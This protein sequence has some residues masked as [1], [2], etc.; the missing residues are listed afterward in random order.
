MNLRSFLEDTITNPII[1]KE[2]RAT[3][4]GS[5][6]FVTFLLMLCLF[7]LVLCGTVAFSYNPR[8][9][10]S[11]EIGQAVFLMFLA[12]VFVVSVFVFPAFSCTAIVSE[13]EKQTYEML[14]VTGIRPWELVLG[15]FFAC[16]CY[17]VTFITA[18]LPL[19][20]SSFLFGG[21]GLRELAIGVMLTLGI[22]S[23][24]TM[25][26][27]F[28]SSAVPSA[29]MAVM[30]TYGPLLFLGTVGFCPCLCCG[31]RVAGG[32]FSNLSGPAGL[33]SAVLTGLGVWLPAMSTFEAVT[34]F[35]LVPGSVWL[36]FT[37]YFFLLTTNRLRPDWANRSRPMRIYFLLFV[38]L[39]VPF[40][41]AVT[42]M[43][44]AKMSAA[45]V[46][47]ALAWFWMI[48]GTCLLPAL[49]FGTENPIRSHRMREELSALGDAWTVRRLM[50][51]G[52][53]SGLFLVL[54]GSAFAAGVGA[55]LLGGAGVGAGIA[56]GTLIRQMSPV[57]G[58][59]WAMLLLFGG[60]GRLLATTATREST[61]RWI[62]GWGVLLLAGGPLALYEFAAGSG[63]SEYGAALLGGSSYLV[64]A[65]GLAEG[66]RVLSGGAGGASVLASWAL[67]GFYA[68]LG[69]LFLLAAWSRRGIVQA[70]LIEA[71]KR[72][73][74][75]IRRRRG[76]AGAGPPQ[77][78]T[79]A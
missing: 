25:L 2:L 47:E 62:L 28:I 51:P 65:I 38:G 49:A 50:F 20:C 63:L 68:G 72:D 75:V 27:L 57:F 4:R 54:A 64:G 45:D 22:S 42:N 48:L 18:L 10:I 61:R 5:K 78:P 36:V 29:R 41:A 17:V 23:A 71:V 40:A 1:V 26:T 66:V 60:L 69:L 13:R 35:F 76:P 8:L 74:K 19:V 70:R 34:Y 12:F 77:G 11:S 9:T 44:A 52:P 32:I 33:A 16:M 58:S 53:G 73:T 43:A 39:F 30:V 14:L 7:T 3:F 37:A 15:K 24:I 46:G 6:F 31:G 55:V 67:P 79:P 59:L 21:V 56:P